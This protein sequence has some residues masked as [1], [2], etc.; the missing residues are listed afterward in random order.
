[1]QVGL[2]AYLTL[3]A[4]LWRLS[5][6]KPAAGQQPVAAAI[7]MVTVLEQQDMVIAN[8][9]AL[10]ANGAL[11]GTSLRKCMRAQAV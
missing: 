11:Q 6:F 8:D 5:A 2:L 1:M 7:A 4:C 3:H 10:V 9:R